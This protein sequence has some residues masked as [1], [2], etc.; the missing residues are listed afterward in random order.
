ME[1]RHFLLK[2][3]STLKYSMIFSVLYAKNALKSLS[4]GC[5]QELTGVDMSS[6]AK[7]QNHLR[8][9]PMG[10]Y[11]LWDT[12]NFKNLFSKFIFFVY[13][14]VL[15]KASR[16]I[17]Q[18]FPLSASPAWAPSNEQLTGCNQ[19]PR[20]YVR[21]MFSSHRPFFLDLFLPQGYLVFQICITSGIPRNR[22][23][24]RIST[25]RDGR[26]LD[27]NISLREQGWKLLRSPPTMYLHG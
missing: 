8:S 4:F 20:L 15:R 12:W 2:L 22:I 27:L 26:F 24:S 3:Y 18:E 23:N 1:S 17:P 21:R 25:P 6:G 16:G 19:P 5:C 13:R 7:P 14:N 11:V 9:T 10:T